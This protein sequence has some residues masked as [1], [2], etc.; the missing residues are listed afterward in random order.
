MGH[1]A[2]YI[3]SDISEVLSVD[4]GCIGEDLS[5][6]EYDVSIAQKIPADLTTTILQDV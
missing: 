3:P 4:M 6:T 1:G 5:C 2:S